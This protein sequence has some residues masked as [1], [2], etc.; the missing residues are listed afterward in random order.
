MH[1]FQCEDIFQIGFMYKNLLKYIILIYFWSTGVVALLA[2]QISVSQLPIMDQMPSNSVQRVF[3]DKDGFL[4]FG[5]LDGLCRYDAYRIHVFRS[6]LN[7]T[8][9]LTNNEITCITE[10]KSG[11]LWIGTMAGISI[12]NKKTYQITRFHDQLLSNQQIR[13]IMVASDSTIWVGGE[14]LLYRFNPDLSLNKTYPEDNQNDGLPISTINSIYEDLYGNIWIALWRSGLYKYQKE[15]DAFIR[16]PEIGTQNNPFR[17]YQDDHK[18]YWICTWGEGIYLFNPNNN[19]QN[20]YT[21]LPVRLREQKKTEETFFSIAQDGIRGYVWVMS[22]SGLYAFEYTKDNTL[23]EVEVSSLFKQT[24]NIFSEVIRDKDGNLWIGAFSEGP[25]TVNFNKPT[26][27]NYNIE[28]IKQKTGIAP[29]ITAIFEDRDGLIWLHQNRLGLTLYNP[30]TNQIKLYSEYPG[31]KN[32]SRMKNIRAIAS[33]TG[34]DEIWL[35]LQE[36]PI[37]NVVQKMGDDIR[38]TRQI[39]LET[40]DTE[41]GGI[42]VFFEDA[43]NNLW[44]A[45]STSLFIKPY[46]NEQITKIGNNIGN[47]TAVTE[48]TRGTIWISTERSGLYKISQNY[49]TSFSELELINISKGDKGLISNNIQSIDADKS[50]NVWIGTKEGNILVYNNIND[51]IKEMTQSCGM[52]GEAILDIVTDKN[53]HVWIS[54]NKRITEFNPKNNASTNYTPSDGMQVNSFLI[55]SFYKNPQSDKIYFGGNL[56]FCS[57]MPTERLTQQPKESQVYITDIKIHNH[58]LLQGNANKKFDNQNLSL[59]IEP[60]DRNLE[61]YFSSLNYNYPLKINYAYKLEGV[62]KDWVYIRNNRQFAV[63]S[64]LKKGT[65][66]FYVKATDENRQWSNKITKLKIIR[67]PAIYETGWAYLLYSIVFLAILYF[68]ARIATNRI[69]L[70]NELKIAQMEKDKSEEITQTK[71]KYFTNISHD[72]LTPLTIISCL[73][74]DIE[75]TSKKKIP[76]YDTMRSNVNRLKRLLQQILDFRKVEKGKMR[77]QV[78]GGNIVSLIQEICYHDFRPI[79]AKKNIDFSFIS[80]TNDIQAWFDADKIDKVVYNLMSNAIKYTPQNGKITVE[81]VKISKHEQKKLA[82][83]ISDTGVGIAPENIN[84]IFTTFYFNKS[85]EA[86]ETNGIGLSLSKDLVELH[87]GQ[88]MIESKPNNGTTIIVEIPI[89]KTSYTEIE[90][91]NISPVILLDDAKLSNRTIDYQDNEE[92]LSKIKTGIINVSIL[93]VE[94]NE[95]LLE[96]VKSILQKRYYVFTATNGLDAINLVRNNDIDIIVSD[97]MMPAMDGIEL[98]RTLKN[99]LETSHISIIL[100]TAKNSINDRVECY[101]AG[102]DAYISKPFELKVL[103]ARINNFV[104]QKQN[105][106]KEFKSNVDINISALEYPSID[107]QFL[108]KAIQIIESHLSESEFDINNFAEHLNLSKSSLYRKIKTMTG[109]SPIE[110]IRNIKLKHACQMLKDKSVSI[111]EVAYAVGFSDPKYFT[112]CFKTEF[113]LTPTEYQKTFVVTDSIQN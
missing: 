48:D 5:T 32:A 103:E 65:Y 39:N 90:I 67:T 18:Q 111:S 10:D 68:L 38:V 16:F 109:L 55:H 42:R 50:G 75:I 69:K 94:D 21:K 57:F 83:K 23:I 35:G 59:V 20:I 31:L 74:D 81:L 104:T 15:T 19:K 84:N 86:G 1:P 60:D 112:S 62:D 89:D 113:T 53:D 106:Q 47:I 80:K 11:N 63:Y 64:H 40:I 71:L 41:A 51:N 100:L 34:S 30:K 43:K 2:Q 4:W 78:S 52:I 70:R 98:C 12:L 91:A 110:F 92:P 37:I 72:L 93:V 46:D 101:N 56:G 107:E 96:L 3:Q 8:N 17:I 73:I 102:A 25:L 36:E 76:Q 54:T 22:L 82:I 33:F 88:I 66:N 9:L 79:I 29:N 26:I 85:R 105:K 99:D 97:V 45:T 44:I 27:I 13:A 77:L 49:N 61:I 6:D 28:S 108:E 24:N 95:E 14:R 7:H 58:S 87:H